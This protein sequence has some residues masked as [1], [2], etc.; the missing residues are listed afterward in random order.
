MSE[1]M[2]SL[3]GLKDEDEQKEQTQEKPIATPRTQRRS[4]TQPSKKDL[5]IRDLKKQ[6]KVLEDLLKE[7]DQIIA[8]LRTKN[9]NSTKITQPI[10]QAKKRKITLER[11]ENKGEF[12]SLAEISVKNMPDDQIITNLNQL[13]NKSLEILEALDEKGQLTRPQLGEII[14]LKRTAT[15][16]RTRNLRT[17]GLVEDNGFQQTSNEYAYRITQKYLDM[18]KVK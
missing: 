17:L 4:K 15:A 3:F 8:E 1:D 5:E 11:K 9:S 10:K 7:K 18:L 16:N 2:L 13:D 12:Q 6:I 14:G